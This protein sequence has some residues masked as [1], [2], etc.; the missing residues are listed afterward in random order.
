MR[1]IPHV[2]HG[3]ARPIGLA[4][5]TD[6]LRATCKP[7]FPEAKSR[8]HRLVGMAIS[9]GVDSMALAYLCS[10][11]REYD[12]S[13]RVC[14]NPVG[15]FR[16]FVVDHGLRQES[17][18]EAEQV[19]KALRRM[20]I[21]ANSFVINWNKEFGEGTDPKAMPNFE[22]AARRARYRRLGRS[23]AHHRIATLLLG[24]HQDDQYETVLMR[25]LN[26][27]RNHALRGMRRASEIP[28]CDGIHG[29]YN[30]G[31]VDDQNTD[32][33]FINYKPDRVTRKH[34]KHELI[35]NIHTQWLEDDKGDDSLTNPWVADEI[36]HVSEYGYLAEDVEQVSLPLDLGLP[37]L[38]IEDAG[39]NIYR[40]MLEFGKDRIIA[41]CLANDIP[42]WEDSTNADP[43]LTTRNTLRHLAKTLRLP[44]AL[45]KPA[46][47]T[48]S[49]KWEA[50]VRARDAEVN[51]WL[52][53]TVLHE[54]EPHVGTVVVQFPDMAPVGQPRHQ[55]SRRYRRRIAQKRAIAGSLIQRI[56]ALISP[57]L[58]LPP[59]ANLQNV[60]S[61]LFP[62]LASPSE[63]QSGAPPKPFPIASVHFT[64]LEA[65][66]SSVAPDA[67]AN[68]R[69][70]YVSRLPGEFPTGPPKNER[71]KLDNDGVPKHY[72]WSLWLPW[73]FYDGRYW[74]RL[75]HRLP[76][77]VV[78]MPFLTEHAKDFRESLGR[79][80]A[81]RLNTVLKRMAPGKVRYTLPAIYAEEYLDLDDVNPRANYPERE[82]AS[83]EEAS[84]DTA[85]N[86]AAKRRNSGPLLP[87][88][89]SK[90]RL[91]ALPT[92]DVQI[93]GL[94][95]WL[96]Y[97][98]RYKRVDRDT[99][100]SAGTF[101]RGSFV[102][103]VRRRTRVAVT[104]TR[105]QKGETK[106]P[107]VKR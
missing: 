40:P 61:R 52:K 62:S 4:E 38:P 35:D 55:S 90:M 86:R 31:W 50:K 100:R 23:C 6:A 54:F 98:T 8:H 72:R 25:L 16:G 88:V 13:F 105:G 83:V 14:D 85:E 44:I 106:C 102:A 9:G 17:A 19:C 75:T 69:T 48:L 99:L 79:D 71:R 77:R 28:E 49:A 34:L 45:R 21:V 47:L 84:E 76:Y 37:P 2:L 58:Q 15:S 59:L 20:G 27:H 60:I 39:V 36:E 89:P 46:V 41:T 32:S 67:L 104:A 53:R 64:P 92:L 66:P 97:E 73:H 65:T 7:R 93:P 29:A 101:S 57:D 30:S 22:S 18:Q 74:I 43:T 33:P 95:K 11:I 78:V 42:W 103:P 87:I 3:L 51:R 10:K 12:P 82:E 107:D 94:E 24:H 26:G 70:W 91:L 1:A 56:L 63:Y 81:R 80:E 5:F 96:S 68:E